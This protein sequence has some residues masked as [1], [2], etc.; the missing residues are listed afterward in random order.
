MKDNKKYINITILA[1]IGGL[2]FPIFIDINVGLSFII[3]FFLIGLISYQGHKKS[4]IKRGLAFIK[5]LGIAPIV[6]VLVYILWCVILFIYIGQISSGHEFIDSVIRSYG[7]PS[8]F[9]KSY[10]PSALD[11]LIFFGLIGGLLTAHSMKQPEDEKLSR[12]IEHIFPEVQT[13]SKLSNY[14]VD[15]ISELACMN[16]VTERII[17]IMDFSQ[18]DKYLKLSIKSHSVIKNLHNNHSFAK[19]N[20]P[21]S[22]GVDSCKPNTEVLGE[23]HEVS[24]VHNISGMSEERHLLKGIATLTHEKKE[25]SLTFPLKIEAEKEVLYQSNSWAWEH[26]DKKWAF[27]SSRYTEERKFV[28][29]N[30]TKIKFEIT[31]ELF[32]TNG[33]VSGDKGDVLAIGPG[34]TKTISHSQLLPNESISFIIKEITGNDHGS[35]TTNKI[36]VKKSKLKVPKVVE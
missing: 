30:F 17:S 24:V 27:H 29:H 18:D 31:A 23:I 9:I 20:M 2:C 34:E 13:E 3:G 11:S 36:D 15:K 1:I 19:S 10:A 7:E 25:H 6:G 12:K 33:N 5:H 16:Q 28:F 8:D 26:M 14:L 21:W 4:Y 35:V 22:F 32:N